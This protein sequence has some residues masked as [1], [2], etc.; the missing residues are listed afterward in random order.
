MRTIFIITDTE[1]YDCQECAHEPLAYEK[2]EDAV[3]AFNE[4]KDTAIKDYASEIINGWEVEESETS[5]SIFE[6]GYYVQNRKVISLT[7][8]PLN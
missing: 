2:K 4:L 7:E 5:I 1:V 6:D 3:K 8:V